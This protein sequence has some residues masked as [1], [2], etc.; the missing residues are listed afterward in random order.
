MTKLDPENQKN[1]Y[2]HQVQPKGGRPIWYVRFRDPTTREI[3]PARSSRQTNENRARDWQR[4]NT[5]AALM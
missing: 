2:L 3:L 5:R 1:Y 4:R